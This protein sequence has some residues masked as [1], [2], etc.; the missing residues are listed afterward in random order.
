MQ[1]FVRFFWTTLY[2]ASEI[3]QLKN[4]MQSLT[5]SYDLVKNIATTVSKNHLAAMLRVNV[6]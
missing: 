2:I 3:E 1:N 4:K 5:T 6:Y